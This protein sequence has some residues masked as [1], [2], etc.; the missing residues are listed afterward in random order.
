MA[1]NE[2]T[3][4]ISDRLMVCGWDSDDEISFEVEGQDNDLTA[5]LNR[6]DVI[7]L[8]DWLTMMLKEKK[9]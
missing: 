4:Y 6:V 2:K 1:N 7:K 9:P 8:R 3:L 5:W